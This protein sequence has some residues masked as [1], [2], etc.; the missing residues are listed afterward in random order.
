MVTA[1]NPITGDNLHSGPT[2]EQYR[3][4]CDA[5]FRKTAEHCG[6]G[7]LCLNCQPRGPNGE[8]PDQAKSEKSH[9]S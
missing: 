5:I 1:K 2:T 8:C 3:N 4:N 9:A 6:L 7:E